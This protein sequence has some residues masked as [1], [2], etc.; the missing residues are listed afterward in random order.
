MSL[1]LKDDVLNALRGGYQPI[2]DSS[3]KSVNWCKL[4]NKGSNVV[5]PNYVPPP[6]MNIH[7]IK[8]VNYCK[9]KHSTKVKAWRIRHGKSCRKNCKFR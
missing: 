2:V 4:P 7:Q 5:N 9:N 3:T 6:S 1:S 8:I